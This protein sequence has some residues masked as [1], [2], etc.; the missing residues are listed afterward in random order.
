MGSLFSFLSDRIVCTFA[1][2][3]ILDMG[4]KTNRNPLT[5]SLPIRVRKSESRSICWRIITTWLGLFWTDVDTHV[6]NVR[7]A[8]PGYTR[9][10]SLNRAI[11]FQV[12]FQLPI[13]QT[14]NRRYLGNT[15]SRFC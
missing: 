9:R 8:S 4:R 7:R 2:T 6:G 10:G 3:D 11:V 13:N 15:V 12:F 1:Q 14:V 5:A